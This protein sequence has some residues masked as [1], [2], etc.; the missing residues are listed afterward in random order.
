M[1]C[2]MTNGI[3]RIECICA[4]IAEQGKNIFRE[5]HPKFSTYLQGQTLTN[6]GTQGLMRYTD[7]ENLQMFSNVVMGRLQLSLTQIKYIWFNHMQRQVQLVNV[8]RALYTHYWRA[9]S[10]PLKPSTVFEGK[11][12]AYTINSN[13]LRHRDACS[14][15]ETQEH[16]TRFFMI[17]VTRCT[18]RMYRLLR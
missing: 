9:I 3:R 10:V 12:S 11:S 6:V 2:Y 14:P 5:Q 16:E 17:G 15:F 1:T 13:C 4:G 18:R 7:I 8:R